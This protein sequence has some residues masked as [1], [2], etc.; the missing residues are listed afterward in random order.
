MCNTTLLVP[1]FAVSLPSFS[2][3]TCFVH[4]LG[5]P[6]LDGLL[7][8]AIPLSSSPRDDTGGSVPSSA[9]TKEASVVRVSAGSGLSDSRASLRLVALK[10]LILWDTEELTVPSLLL[11]DAGPQFSL[12]SCLSSTCHGVQQLA[13]TPCLVKSR[14][15][16]TIPMLSL[17]ST[18]ATMALKRPQLWLAAELQLLKSTWKPRNS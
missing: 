10:V 6:G 7:T 5:F 3:F 16:A 11:T 14:Q 17:Q 1:W 8:S 12:W 4:F 9:V 15:G 18:Q 2:R 13:L